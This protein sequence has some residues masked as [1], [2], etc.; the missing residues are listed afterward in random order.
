[1]LPLKT[2]AM[3]PTVENL[4][5]HAA[6]PLPRWLVDAARARSSVTYVQGNRRRG[7][8][9]GFATIFSS[10]MGVLAGELT[11]RTLDVMPDC[12][13]LNDFVVR[14]R[15]KMSGGGAGSF[16]ADYLGVL[17]LAEPS[18]RPWRTRKTRR[19][20]GPDYARLPRAVCAH[21]RA[22]LTSSS[23]PLRLGEAIPGV[24]CSLT[25]PRHRVHGYGAPRDARG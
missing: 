9:A 25:A 1:M 17:R 4:R 6:R 24:T 2:S 15:D 14:K 16:M 18:P 23:L 3:R 13:A 8:Q 22:A 19:R 20:V 5:Q 12:S 21:R 10:R 11:Y 7:V